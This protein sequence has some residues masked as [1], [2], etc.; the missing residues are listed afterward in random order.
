M[1]F[2]KCFPSFALALCLSSHSLILHIMPASVLKF[3][4]SFVSFPLHAQP[5]VTLFPLPPCPSV[6][7]SV[8]SWSSCSASWLECCGRE[9]PTRLDT[10]SSSARTTA[11]AAAR[12][13]RLARATHLRRPLTISS[14]PK[15]H[16][17]RKKQGDCPTRSNRWGVINE[18]V[19]ASLC[20]RHWKAALFWRW[21][22]Y[23]TVTSTNFQR[24]D[25]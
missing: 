24:I 8:L 6:R 12:P 20:E 23:T 25:C 2:K 14:E 11:L 10:R 5:S 22:R 13:H 21:G 19:C 17:K 16:R 7:P 9:T 18:N 4:L 3:S 1:D 15:S